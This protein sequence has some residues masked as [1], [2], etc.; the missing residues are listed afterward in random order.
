MWLAFASGHASSCAPLVS[1]G[2]PMRRTRPAAADDGTAYTT[3]A[4]ALLT[5]TWGE[6][7]LR[8]RVRRVNEIWL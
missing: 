4:V 1:V 7:C 3:N 2:V 5:M 6:P 8:V